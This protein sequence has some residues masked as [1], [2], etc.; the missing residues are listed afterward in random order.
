M[1]K[2]LLVL[3]L[4]IF[5]GCYLAFFKLLFGY[6]ELVEIKGSL[7]KTNSFVK[8]DTLKNKQVIKNTYLCFNLRDDKRVYTLKVH[9]DSVY[10][11]VTRL[12]V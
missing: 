3:L 1:K 11:G 2:I 4:L 7:K 12:K 9:I 6:D 8:T 10:G 5:Y